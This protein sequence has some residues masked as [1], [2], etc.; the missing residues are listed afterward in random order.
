VPK[1]DSPFVRFALEP[2]EPR[3][4]LAV[5]AN[6][7]D[8]AN[9]GNGEW[10]VDPATAITHAQT[11]LGG[12]S[13]W[14]TVA[15]PAGYPSSGNN[16]MDKFFYWEKNV[17]GLEYVIVKAADGNGTYPVGGT[18]TYTSQLLTSAHNAGLKVLPYFYIYGGS[19]THK[20]GSTTTIQGEINI[21]NSVMNSVGGDGA[22]FDIEG[23]YSG[24]TGGPSAAFQQ[25]MA[26]IGKSAAGDGSGSRDTLFMAYSSFPYPSLHTTDPWADLG[27]YCD[28]AM[29]QAYWQDI[30]KSPG[31]SVSQ[32]VGQSFTGTGGPTRI[33]N[34]VYREYSPTVSGS[35]FFNKPNSVKPIIFTGQT[36]QGDGVTTAFPTSDEMK[37]FAQYIK[38]NPSASPSFSASVNWFRQ[39]TN[40]G[41]ERG[42]VRD[43]LTQIGDLPGTPSITA[44]TNGLVTTT[45]PTLLNWANTSHATSYDVFL[46]GSKVAA[47]IT[48]SQFSLSASL[49]VADHTW[50]VI[51]NDLFGSTSGPTWTFKVVPL[52]PTALSAT[53][54]SF[55]SKIAVTWTAAANAAG[56]NIYRNTTNNS[57]TASV[58]GSTTSVT[59]YD[60]NT[61]T[62]GTTYFYWAKAKNAS[63]TEGAF[64]NGDSGVRSTD[65]TAPTVIAQTFDRETA[66]HKLVFQFSEAMLVSTLDA[67][68]ISVIN[69]DVQ[70]PTPFSPVSVSYDSTTHTATY[71]FSGVLADANYQATLAVGKVSDTSNNSNTASSVFNFFFL[72]AD[73][74]ADRSVSIQ[75]FNILAADFG[76]SGQSYSQGN[77]DYSADGVIGITDFNILAAHFGKSLSNPDA[78]AAPAALSTQSISAT[79]TSTSAASR[80]N[81]SPSLLEEAGLL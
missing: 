18:A 56:Y 5:F 16:N 14:T 63:S 25:Y 38:N 15:L 74:L 77:Y 45:K 60:D 37:E 72:T 3:R 17:Q 28:A 79:T 26:G 6:G 55:S 69:R 68:D 81:A 32:T 80:T 8:S 27:N 48:T 10:I 7:I 44:P 64:S 43:A 40:N 62:A 53:D 46:D 47:A 13:G 1:L 29:P 70:S 65:T 12:F 67:S 51:A 75:D 78:P 31:G 11:G 66:T 24:A 9:L 71:N 49:T 23:E 2:L 35:L 50:Q 41:D 4:L 36:Y 20:T 76:K 34:D 33:V 61:A 19:A 39:E 73:G 54:N 58:I 59:S 22:M 42:A 30:G 52:A 57:A 21:F